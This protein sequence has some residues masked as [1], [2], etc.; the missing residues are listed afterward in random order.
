MNKFITLIKSSDIFSNTIHFRYGKKEFHETILGGLTS[1][2]IFSLL[3]YLLYNISYERINYLNPSLT[4]FPVLNKES[5][6][7]YNETALNI[8]IVPNYQINNEVY[9]TLDTSLIQ[10]IMEAAT[11]TTYSNGTKSRNW[12]PIELKKCDKNDFDEDIQKV[13]EQNQFDKGL[14]ISK[15]NF[16][17]RGVFESEIFK[18]L[19]MNIVECKFHKQ[20]YKT[21]QE[22]KS[23]EELLESIDNIRFSFYYTYSQIDPNN[24]KKP[25]Y[26]IIGN[27]Q[28]VLATS[29]YKRSNFFFA[30]DVISTDDNLLFNTPYENNRT[31]ISFG[32][33]QEDFTKSDN[34]SLIFY[35]AFFR[36]YPSYNLMLRTYKKIP[37]IL[38]EAGSLISYLNFIMIYL[39]GYYNRS[40]LELS[41]MN[42]LLSYDNIDNLKKSLNLKKIDDSVNLNILQEINKK[43]NNLNLDM[44]LPNIRRNSVK[45]SSVYYTGNNSHNKFSASKFFLF[46]CRKKFK[47]YDL[48]NKM[49]F[50]IDQFLDIKNFM[51]MNE[52][53][54]ILKDFTNASKTNNL[55]EEPNDLIRIATK[56]KSNTQNVINHS[57][58]GDLLKN[59]FFN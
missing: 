16:T 5:E 59:N 2:A 45:K 35:T 53:F 4:S 18:F 22:C 14:C 33:V 25:F 7:F 37:S 31:Y 51:V 48:Y 57:F 52:E 42:H 10:I 26:T 12:E 28:I 38:A 29:S 21:D 32:D 43:R 50:L 11:Y 30:P 55:R 44:P 3:I 9:Y 13:F 39:I 17:I 47:N 20:K 41:L 58:N 19:K 34:D 54:L 56:E 24:Y 6:I 46:G 1:I 27:Q 8:I 40:L 15:K 23:R 36:V 49:R